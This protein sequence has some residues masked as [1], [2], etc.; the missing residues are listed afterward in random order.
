MVRLELDRVLVRNFFPGDAEG[1]RRV[2]VSYSGSPYAKFDHAWPTSEEGIGEAIGYFASRD[3]FLAV[4]VRGSG[5]LVGMISMVSEGEGRFGFGYVFELES[6]GVGYATEACRLVLDHAFSMHG[7]G[8][9][10]AGTA[11]VNEPSCR[12]L[13]RL[14]FRRVSEEVTH[15]QVASDGSPYEFLGL[16]FELTR[17]D[18]VKAKH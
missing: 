18:W 13:E 16:T 15:L 3:D 11:A 5:R 7:A 14:G 1:L 9:V 12:L 10:S 4:C 6:R 17:E 2:A 8:V